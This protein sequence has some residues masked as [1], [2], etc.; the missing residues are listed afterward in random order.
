MYRGRKVFYLTKI[1]RIIKQNFSNKN[2]QGNKG[3]SQINPI[4]QRNNE[5]VNIHSSYTKNIERKEPVKCWGC[6]G[7]P[8]ASTFPNRKKTVSNIHTIQEEMIVGD[9]ARTMPMIN[10][11]L[12]NMQEDYQTS[13]VQV[14]GKLNQT[15]ISILIDPWASL[16]YISPDLVEKCKLSIEKFAKYWL[17]Q[18]ATRAKIKVISF[19]KNCTVKMDQCENFVKINV[20]LPLGSY[21][22]LIGME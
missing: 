12:E 4:G 20:L 17:V 11:T 3:N 7:P 9:L 14:E 8:Y 15:P 19:V 21:D 10:A 16:S 18:L 22:M 2:F 5:P 13:I 1:L 6:N